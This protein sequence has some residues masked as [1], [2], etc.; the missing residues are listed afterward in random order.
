M[1]RSCRIRGT[2]PSQPSRHSYVKLVPMAPPESSQTSTDLCALT[3]LSA[4]RSP[5]Q[6]ERARAI[7]QRSRVSQCALARSVGVHPSTLSRWERGERRPTGLAAIRWIECLEALTAQ[8][9]SR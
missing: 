9:E 2:I 3:A 5:G 4:S 6:P 7:R 8:E 1:P